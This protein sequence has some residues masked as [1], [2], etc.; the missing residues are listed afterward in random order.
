MIDLTSQIS[1]MR[2][3]W[4][5]SRSLV[6]FSEIFG[7]DSERKWGTKPLAYVLLFPVKHSNYHFLSI[8]LSSWA[9]AN[10]NIRFHKADS[11]G[12]LY[13]YLLYSNMWYIPWSCP[14]DPLLTTQLFEC[15]TGNNKTYAKGLTPHFL[16]RLFTDLILQPTGIF[17][18][19]SG[20]LN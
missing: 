19:S 8:I 4:K 7:T 5:F 3:V 2:W 6:H 10:V 18:R 1:I 14:L 12:Q 15:F 11:A 17:E 16:P 20:G 9:Q 13:L